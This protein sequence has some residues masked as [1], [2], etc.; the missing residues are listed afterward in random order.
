MSDPK[1]IDE[2]TYY[3]AHPVEAALKIRGL[4][5]QLD[6]LNHRNDKLIHDT[7]KGCSVCGNTPVV[8]VPD[9]GSNTYW[10]CGQCVAEELEDRRQYETRLNKILDC[11]ASI[12]VARKPSALNVEDAEYWFGRLNKAVKESLDNQR[13]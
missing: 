6:A 13:S 8:H 12:N 2:A 3:E 1:L 10:L 7:G 4:R 5:S 9:E 11:L